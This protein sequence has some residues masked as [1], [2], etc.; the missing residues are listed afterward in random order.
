ME[1]EGGGERERK[2][3]WELCTC[4]DWMGFSREAR[5]LLSSILL[6]FD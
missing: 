4:K 3:Q 5:E 6:D 1:R 2:E